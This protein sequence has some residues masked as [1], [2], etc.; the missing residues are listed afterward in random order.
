MEDNNQNKNLP[1]DII[2]PTTPE[3]SEYQPIVFKKVESTEPV[4]ENKTEVQTEP[5]TVANSTELAKEKI[6][7]KPKESKKETSVT[8]EPPNYLNEKGEIDL[9]KIIHNDNDRVV[10]NNVKPKKVNVKKIVLW[11]LVLLVVGFFG[12]KFAI[13]KIQE[14]RVLMHGSKKSLIKNAQTYD[15]YKDFEKDWVGVYKNE[16]NGIALAIYLTSDDSYKLVFY[17]DWNDDKE[18]IK[19]GI[20]SFELEHTLDGKNGYIFNY[21][22]NYKLEKTETGIYVVFIELNYDLGT[23]LEGNYEKVHI[24]NTYFDG[25]YKY[26]DITLSIFTFNNYNQNLLI[27]RNGSNYYYEV[28]TYNEDD[29]PFIYKDNCDFRKTEFGDNYTYTCEEYGSNDLDLLIRNI[30]FTKK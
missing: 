25:I 24:D 22:D 17:D 7:T 23:K 1:N 8:T 19:T 13:K 5:S 20:S 21:N 16:D 11:V 4:Q 12:T 2:V 18:A 6:S 29:Q 28:A 9:N 14:N 10:V 3:V 26:D 27:Y 15:N 30:P